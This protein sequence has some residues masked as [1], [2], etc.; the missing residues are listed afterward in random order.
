MRPLNPTQEIAGQEPEGN[1]L[2]VGPAKL[3]LGGF[4]GVTALYRSTN[5]GGGIGTGFGTIPYADTLQ[6]SISETRLSA[7]GSRLSLRV[8]ASFPERRTGF[9]ALSGYFEMDFNGSTPGTVAVTSTSV[10]LRLR[11]S[12]AVV[13]YGDAFFVSAGQAFTLMTPAKDQLTM[14][15]SDYEMTQA[16]DTNYVVGLIWERVP[17]VR[18]AWRPSKQFNW[19]VSVENPE[20]QLG[21]ALVTLPRCCADDISAQY[22]TGSNE[23]AVPNPMPDFVTRV[24][25]N[26]NNVVHI[27]AGGVLRVF[28]HT[29]APYD[30]TFK[31]VGGG[32]SVNLRV[33]ATSG[34]HLIMQSGFGSGMGRYVG[35]LAPDTAFRADGSIAPI[36]TK[37]WV[38]GVEQKISSTMSAA[39]YYSGVNTDE[40]AEIDTGGAY[41]G[42]GFPGSS[43]SNN[44]TI[45]EVTATYSWAPVTTA[46]RGSAQLSVQ[47]SWLSREPWYQGDGPA[48]AKAFLFFAQVRYNLP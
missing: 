38:A 17:Q 18:L 30:D 9:H 13:Q 16:V 46:D 20:Q 35:G 31:S 6:G 22:N 5:G 14:W 3:R 45:R 28:R 21:R 25:L 41:I 47:G 42:F 2:D 11:H 48:S 4:V 44:R 36:G 33:S 15:P 19:A 7:Q 29:V 27:D 12:F 1:A 8:D 24:A 39:G 10:G 26:P 32:G 37:S 43:N 23:L 40:R 34:T